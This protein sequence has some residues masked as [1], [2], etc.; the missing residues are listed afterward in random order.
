MREREKRE[1]V[2]ERGGR[3]NERERGRA[4]RRMREIGIEREGGGRVSTCMCGRDR[5]IMSG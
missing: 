2:R 5:G 4:G 3:K 1:R